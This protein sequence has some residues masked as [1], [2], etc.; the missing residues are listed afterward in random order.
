MDY[1]G[2]RIVLAKNDNGERKYGYEISKNGK[3]ISYEDKEKE[4]MKEVDRI[5]DRHV[6]VEYLLINKKN[7]S[8]SR[9]TIKTTESE[10]DQKI[11]ELERKYSNDKTYYLRDIRKVYDMK[12][13]DKLDKAIKVFD[14][15]FERSGVEKAKKAIR[16]NINNI[17]YSYET[18]GEKVPKR[19]SK[20]DAESFI[21]EFNLNV[22]VKE[23][24]TAWI[25]SNI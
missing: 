18:G 6:T 25:E 10:V 22:S 12:T 21:D 9:E 8:K 20:Y 3:I 1:R 5:L 17:R 19:I 4:A 7:D 13:A 23:F 15:S 16:S 24:Q 2:Y 11:K 14:E